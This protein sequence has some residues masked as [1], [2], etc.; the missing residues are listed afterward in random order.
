MKRL[1]IAIDCDDV[2]V[3]TT[4]YFVNAYN[5]LHGT[6]G[7]L[8]DARNVSP[9][10]WGVGE[11]EILDRW[12][13]LTKTEE[14]KLLQPDAEVVAVLRAL[15]KDHEL[16]LVTARKEEEREF[17]QAMLDRELRG[18]FNSMEFVGWEG[19]KGQ[20]CQRLRTDV[21]IDDNA[22]HLH[23]ALECGLPS[24]GALLFGD[25]DWNKDERSHNA[26][27]HCHDWTAVKRVID[28]IAQ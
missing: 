27:V 3:K 7:T 4:P 13:A 18:V 10:I 21:L 2:L 11:Q 25:Y 14:Y 9:E 8:A 6:K 24:G 19:S 26:L 23:D 28:R 5:A 15:A 22:S 12:A 1:V 20:I 16:H 17:T